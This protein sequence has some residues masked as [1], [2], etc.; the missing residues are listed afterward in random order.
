MRS[1]R[2][3]IYDNGITV[4]SFDPG[5]AFSSVYERDNLERALEDIYRKCSH[6]WKAGDKVKI[7]KAGEKDGE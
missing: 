1:L 2:I 4:Q 6:D 7:I 3:D 5:Y